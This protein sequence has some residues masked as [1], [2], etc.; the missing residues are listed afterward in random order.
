MEIKDTLVI[1]CEFQYHPNTQKIPERIQLYLD[2][3]KPVF[4]APKYK[5]KYPSDYPVSRMELLI[6]GEDGIQDSCTQQSLLVRG[7]K[8]VNSRTVEICGPM[9]D[10]CLSW[11]KLD[12]ESEGFIP[13][14]NMDYSATME[15]VV[16]AGR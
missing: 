9:A 14:I 1:W 12:L 4:Y 15:E 10:H 3:D 8:R 6:S 7:L 16:R 13:E 2:A 5:N 11:L